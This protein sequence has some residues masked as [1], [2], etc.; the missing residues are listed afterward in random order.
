M[1]RGRRGDIVKEGFVRR[2]QR[3]QDGSRMKTSS[4]KTIVKA[5][6]AGNGSAASVMAAGPAGGFGKDDQATKG[7]RRMPWH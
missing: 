7:F 3:F 6:L 1:A 4:D 5:M 2:L